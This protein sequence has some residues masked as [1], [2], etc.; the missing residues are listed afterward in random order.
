MKKTIREDAGIT[1]TASGSIAVVCQPLM[2]PMGLIRRES[3]SHKTTKYSNSPRT[4]IYKD[5]G[6]PSVK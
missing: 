6:T 1:T 3:E 5:R 2:S 4:E